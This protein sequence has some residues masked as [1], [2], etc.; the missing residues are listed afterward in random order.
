MLIIYLSS[1]IIWRN[2]FH[3]FQ[4][5]SAHTVHMILSGL[6]F[7][8][9]VPGM[10]T[11]FANEM[12]SDMF[13]SYW[14]DNKTCYDCYVGNN[15]NYF[16]TIKHYLLWLFSN[17]NIL[18]YNTSTLNST[19]AV[20]IYECDTIFTSEICHPNKIAAKVEFCAICVGCLSFIFLFLS[21]SFTCCLI[22]HCCGIRYKNVIN[23]YTVLQY[24]CFRSTVTPNDSEESEFSNRTAPYY[25][26]PPL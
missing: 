7:I 10:N 8:F 19:S 12:L 17:R 9:L 13:Y 21:S 5:K 25:S 14:T 1:K 26:Q 16:S 20:Q 22:C 15:Q 23:T 11:L 24:R 2:L 3:N 18:G 4:S 6:G